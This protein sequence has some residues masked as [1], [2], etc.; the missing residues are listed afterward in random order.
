M[1]QRITGNKWEW[2]DN[3]N[4][5]VRCFCLLIFSGVNCEIEIDECFE[6][7]PCYNG[8]TCEDLIAEYRCHCASGF[9]G[10]FT[11]LQFTFL[12]IEWWNNFLFWCSQWCYN[13]CPKS[14]WNWG[15]LI[16]YLSI[17]WFHN[18]IQHYEFGMQVCGKEAVVHSFSPDS[19]DFV[20]QNSTASSLASSGPGAV[21]DFEDPCINSID[22]TQR[23][24]SLTVSCCHVSLSSR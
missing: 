1:N 15:K 13:G 12:S 9:N 2:E 22:H 20:G 5:D 24:T 23:Y 11:I 21:F 4:A 3:S 10:M 19:K 6:F 7:S 18:S 16:P 17:R 8:A 14:F